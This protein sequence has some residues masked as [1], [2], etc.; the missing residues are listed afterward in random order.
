MQV[1]MVRG[2]PVL[3]MV[4]SDARTLMDS[5]YLLELMGRNLDAKSA[6]CGL[7]KGAASGIRAL[8]KSYGAKYLDEHGDFALTEK[9][10]AAYSNDPVDLAGHEDAE[11]A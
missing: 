7:A 10:A 9:E 1:R 2:R 5:V 4:K 8:V 3:S 6:E 11:G